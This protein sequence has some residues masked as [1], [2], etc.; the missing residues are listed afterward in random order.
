MK[1]QWPTNHHE[2]YTALL[3]S[4]RLEEPKRKRRGAS[5]N[6]WWWVGQ[7]GPVT[8]STTATLA[9]LVMPVG[10]ACKQGL[11]HP[12]VPASWRSF[13]N[14]EPSPLPGTLLR[15]WGQLFLYMKGKHSSSALT[16]RATCILMCLAFEIVETQTVLIQ[17]K[18]WHNS[19]V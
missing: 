1:G 15:P 14:C 5:M 18:E 8:V 9:P 2:K 4:A 3:Q 17:K 19:R 10:E 16:L 13:R 7:L 11:L 12:L 6:D